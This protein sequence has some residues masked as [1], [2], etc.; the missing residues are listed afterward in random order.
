MPCR[1]LPTAAPGVGRTHVI[2]STKKCNWTICAI[3]LM[4]GAGPVVTHTVPHTSATSLDV[5]SG[6]PSTLLFP[7][8]DVLSRI[9]PKGSSPKDNPSALLCFS[10]CLLSERL[11]CTTWVSH[12]LP[13][14]LPSLIKVTGDIKGHKRKCHIV[15]CGLWFW[16]ARYRE[17]GATHTHWRVHPSG[18]FFV[19]L[20]DADLN[21]S[22]NSHKQDM[23]R[24]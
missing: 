3:R 1:I 15:D 18:L 23:S 22:P 12:Y 21:I 16:W 17:E 9:S 2:Q 7:H 14:A 10:S 24:V 20:F 5:S 8:L 11:T 6:Q 19:V 4:P 13:Q